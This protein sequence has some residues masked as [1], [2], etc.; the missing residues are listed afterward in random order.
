M[1]NPP[2]HGYRFV[3]TRQ[4][5]T[6]ERAKYRVEVM[7]EAEVVHADAILGEGEVELNVFSADL[8]KPV[9]DFVR[10]LLAQVSRQRPWPRR[11]NRWREIG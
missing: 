1:I 11:V 6:D 8:P 9:A 2:T 10:R 5:Y 4:E 7:S 3:L